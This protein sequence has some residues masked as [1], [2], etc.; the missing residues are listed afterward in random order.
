[1]W[2]CKVAVFRRKNVQ[3]IK[4]ARY[5]SNNDSA[6]KYKETKKMKIQKWKKTWKIKFQVITKRLISLR[7][8]ENPNSKNL[9]LALNRSLI[10]CFQY[11]ASI[12]PYF[13]CSKNVNELIW[14]VSVL[15]I[16]TCNEFF[17]FYSLSFYL[18]LSCLQLLPF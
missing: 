6:Q 1:M 4:H 18:I 10:Q 16:F 13:P 14:K 3:S 5:R 2:N 17:Q 8:S 9:P 7:L 15:M 12:L 11:C